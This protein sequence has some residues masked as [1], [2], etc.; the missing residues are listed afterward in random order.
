MACKSNQVV[1][2][3]A[4]VVR[5]L[6]LS[7]CI[8]LGISSC[9]ASHASDA[10]NSYKELQFNFIGEKNKFS[11]VHPEPTL[12]PPSERVL[13]SLFDKMPSYRPS[14]EEITMTGADSKEQVEDIEAI[15]TVKQRTIVYDDV[16]RNEGVNK[17]NSMNIEITGNGQ[18]K[19]SV[20]DSKDDFGNAIEERVDSAI[21]SGMN[22]GS[23]DKTGSIRTQV[24][25]LNID[26]S[27]ISVSA[28]NTVQGGTAIATSNIKI[29]P[30]QII[31]GPSEAS[32]K[33][34]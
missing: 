16:Q 19:Q 1:L 5:I 15:N 29:E 7:F 8:L 27:G 12:L 18:E 23:G 33:L 6:S 22:H 32:E 20:M 11:Q 25:D 28:I 34:K 14:N 13:S 3:K 2:N 31:I 26:V 30:V 21:T 10:L 17:S 24:N 4:L 9:Q